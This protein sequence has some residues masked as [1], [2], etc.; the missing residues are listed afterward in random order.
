MVVQYINSASKYNIYCIS[1]N[2]KKYF[3]TTITAFSGKTISA[4]EI[5]LFRSAEERKI[6]EDRRI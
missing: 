2:F 4:V 6:N 1:D 3:F 5:S